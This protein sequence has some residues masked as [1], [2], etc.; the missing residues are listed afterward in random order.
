MLGVWGGEGEILESF[1]IYLYFIYLLAYLPSELLAYLLAY[2]LTYL[3][4]DLLAYLHTYLLT[5]LHTYLLTLTKMLSVLHFR[6]LLQA[7]DKLVS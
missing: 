3:L 6:H 5:Y 7:Y 4:T 1:L 2:L